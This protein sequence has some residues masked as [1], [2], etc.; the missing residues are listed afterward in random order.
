MEGARIVQ[1]ES[2]TEIPIQTELQK[3]W[4][5]T[6]KTRGIQKRKTNEAQE[7]CTNRTFTDVYQREG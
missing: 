6:L 2:V 1:P 4:R 5:E 3:R 7:S